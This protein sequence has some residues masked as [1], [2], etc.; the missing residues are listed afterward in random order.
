M[1]HTLEMSSLTFLSFFSESISRKKSA[2]KS[3]RSEKDRKAQLCVVLSR[4]CP[5]TQKTSQTVNGA[6]QKLKTSWESG[7]R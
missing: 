7:M 3:L 6:P 2:E 1:L 4:K 5:E